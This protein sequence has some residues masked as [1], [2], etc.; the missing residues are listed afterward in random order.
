MITFFFDKDQLNVSLQ[1]GDVIHFCEITDDDGFSVNQTPMKTVGPI[2]SIFENLD[3]GELKIGC[4]LEA[5]NSYPNPE[6]KNFIFFS[7]DNKAN[8]SSPV[9]YYSITKFVNNDLDKGEMF[10]ASCDVSMSSK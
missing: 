9:G 3:T 1:I 2:K 5:G 10:T 4:N 6:N 8:M 7:K